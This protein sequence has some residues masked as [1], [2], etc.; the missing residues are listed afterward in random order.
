[1]N[2]LR[3]RSPRDVLRLYYAAMRAKSADELADLYAVD[4]IHEFPFFTPNR[5][6]RLEGREAVRSAYREG[7]RSAPLTIDSIEDVFVFEATDPEVVV[8]QFRARATL[9]STGQA[10]EFTGLLVLRVRD[11]FVVHTRDFI[12]ALGVAKALGR[13]P[14]APSEPDARSS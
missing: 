5:P 6:P 9:S 8:G 2:T 12:D 1:M 11:G 13:P 3:T 4:A 7:W 10:A 14:F